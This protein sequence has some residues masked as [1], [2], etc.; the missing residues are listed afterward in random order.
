M[1]SQVSAFSN[2]P[3]N[4]VTCIGFHLVT[5]SALAMMSDT[6]PSLSFC[7]PID[8]AYLCSCFAINNVNRRSYCYKSRSNGVIEWSLTGTDEVNG[9]STTSGALG[10]GGL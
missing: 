2:V 9:L 8:F 6:L 7:I 5:V 1:R 10:M 3:S 4:L